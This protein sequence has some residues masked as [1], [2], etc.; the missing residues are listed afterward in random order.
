MR[1]REYSVK[2]RPD[3]RI[4]VISTGPFFALGRIFYPILMLILFIAF[5][6]ALLAGQ[7]A[8]AGFLLLFFAILMPNFA[9]RAK[10]HA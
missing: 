2:E 10:K 9:K 5:I 7:I 6:Q 8:G 3:G 1:Y 4:R